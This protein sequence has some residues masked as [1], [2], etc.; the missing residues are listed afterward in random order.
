V[1]LLLRRR[2]P[3][4]GLQSRTAIVP[5]PRRKISH[6]TALELLQLRRDYLHLRCVTFGGSRGECDNSMSFPVYTRFA[7]LS[8]IQRISSDNDNVLDGSRQPT[9]DLRRFQKLIQLS[10]SNTVSFNRRQRNNLPHTE[11]QPWSALVD[12]RPLRVLRGKDMMHSSLQLGHSSLQKTL[13]SRCLRNAGLFYSDLGGWQSRSSRLTW[14]PTSLCPS[15][16]CGAFSK[17]DGRASD[18]VWLFLLS[19]LPLLLW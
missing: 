1:R 18:R 19:E 7:H 9:Y 5:W 16:W 4:L 12:T 13:D 14:A 2:C 6:N 15:T 3:S 11:Q 17:I 8:Y 10:G